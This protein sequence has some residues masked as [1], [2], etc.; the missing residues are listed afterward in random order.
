MLAC[1]NVCCNA[2]L[3]TWLY[4]PNGVLQHIR[5]RMELCITRATQ[6]QAALT[7]RHVQ[8]LPVDKGVNQT[9]WRMFCEVELPCA[10]ELEV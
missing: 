9:E 7:R 5:T 8:V 6:A 10:H 3:R 4:I 2:L 1:C